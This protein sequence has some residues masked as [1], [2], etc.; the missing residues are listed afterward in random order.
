MNRILSMALTGVLAGFF[1]SHAAQ[2]QTAPTTIFVNGKVLTVDAS[3]SEVEAVAVT[4]N[5]ISALGSTKQIS[6]LADTNTVVIDL[7]GRTL[8][9]G[10]IDNHN[11]LIFNA[12][13]KSAKSVDLAF[14]S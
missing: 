10:L 6:A 5:K 12:G 8:I 13:S 14:I 11:H 4:A 3:F 7:D 1:A 2:A 9:P